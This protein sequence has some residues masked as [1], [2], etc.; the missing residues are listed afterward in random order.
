M[1]RNLLFL[2]ALGL[3]FACGNNTPQQNDIITENISE[4]QQ[5]TSSK[6]AFSVE[7]YKIEDSRILG[8]RG[9]GEDAYELHAYFACEIDIPVTD[10]QALYDS[11]CK[12]FAQTLRTDQN[13][14]IR[15]VKAM[16]NHYK[17]DILGHNNDEDP[18]G[19]EKSN[20][21]KMLT[22]N[23][24]YVTYRRYDFYEETFAPRS[25]QEWVCVTFDSR[26]GKR[27]TCQMINKDETLK[28]LVMNTLLEQFFRDWQQDDLTNILNFD[29]E[30]LEERGFWLPD[31]DPYIFNDSLYFFYWEHDIADR[32]AGQPNC[33]L[34]YN[35]VEK[36][37]TEEG[38]A[39][40]KASK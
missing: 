30:D 12:W 26:T 8:V 10:N 37:L 38:K 33:G 1:K 34:P 9:E 35:S 13:E 19:F 27:F 2:A 28:E 5:E 25:E 31:T 39:F 4:S 16:V 22:A 20:D 24:G 6:D 29:P 36:Y 18:Y 21:F 11:I 3:F 14:D 32:V 7:T 15:D 40:F 23:D 17:D